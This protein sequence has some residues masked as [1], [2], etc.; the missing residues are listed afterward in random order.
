ML[1][2]LQADQWIAQRLEMGLALGGVQVV[3]VRREG[4]Y[5]SPPIRATRHCLR[6]V[7]FNNG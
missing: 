2:D 6:V 1:E 5:E 3:I 7:L 4:F